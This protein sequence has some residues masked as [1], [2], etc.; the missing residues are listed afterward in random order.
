MFILA[1]DQGVEREQGAGSR[2]EIARTA[3]GEGSCD[4]LGT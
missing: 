2:A 1:E 4:A 3:D